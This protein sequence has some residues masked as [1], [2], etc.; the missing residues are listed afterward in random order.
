MTAKYDA[1]LDQMVRDYSLVTHGYAGKAPA[2]PYPML[3]ER[4]S[5]CPV[6]QGDLLQQNSIPSMADYMMT[7]RPVVTLYR[8]KDIHSVLMN[9]N[10]WLSHIVGD[11]F[12]AAVDNLLL[13]AMDGEDHDKYRKTLQKPFMRGQIR[14]LIDTL[15]RPVVVNEFVNKL[16]PKG[17]ADLLREFA[18]PFPIRAMYAYF[19]FPHNEDLLGNL[20][21]WAIQVVAAPQTDPELANITIPQS[22]VAGQSMFTTLLPI[23][24]QYRARGEMRNDILGYMMTAEHEGEKFSDEEIANFVRMLLLAAGEAPGLAV[25]RTSSDEQA[26]NKANAVP[27]TAAVN[28]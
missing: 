18:L 7:G 27:A 21:S 5:Q 3:A 1:M 20:A 15:I 14:E 24:E 11:G 12:G 19:G 13:T 26:P 23:V 25:V 2:N 9:P 17:K 28:T 8:Y 6:M 16:K 22:M 4:R 10:D